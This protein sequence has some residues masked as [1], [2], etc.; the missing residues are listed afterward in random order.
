M[1]SSIVYNTPVAES[2]SS[3]YRFLL[4]FKQVETLAVTIAIIVQSSNYSSEINGHFAT[5]S[6]VTGETVAMCRT[7][8]SAGWPIAVRLLYVVATHICED[9]A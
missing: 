2:K 7:V 5:A 4:H 9:D 8:I 6:K 1:V 3:G